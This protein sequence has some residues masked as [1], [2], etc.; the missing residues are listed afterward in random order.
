LGEKE[1]D[2][3]ENK[4]LNKPDIK[5]LEKAFDGD[6]DLVLFFLAWIKHGKNGVKAYQELHPNTDYGSAATLASRLLKK[7]D[8]AAILEVY[9]AGF[10]AYFKQLSEGHQAMKW[11][12]FTGEKEPDHKV[13]KEYNKTIG[14][15]LGVEKGGVET[16]NLTQ[17]NYY[18]LT[19]EQ[20]DDLIESKRRQTG[21]SEI[22]AGERAKNPGEP[23]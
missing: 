18:N 22:I 11:N 8:I 1:K 15:L 9:G 20:L 16:P 14:M 10:D 19:D 17:N 23:A 5:A 7:V 6:L 12:D 3:E 21:T 13:R 4:G 2:M